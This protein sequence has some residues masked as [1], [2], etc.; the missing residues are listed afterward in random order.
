MKG[1]VF[2]Y[3][4]DQCKGGCIVTYSYRKGSGLAG[5]QQTCA[6]IGWGSTLSSD[7]STS[8]VCK[9]LSIRVA[10]PSLLSVVLK[11]VV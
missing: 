5:K 2:N 6:D 1:S 9:G 3:P 11:L 7:S 8:D 4:R 10:S